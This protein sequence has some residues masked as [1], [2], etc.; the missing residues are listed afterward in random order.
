MITRKQAMRR[1]T[2]T[3]TLLLV[4][5]AVTVP[6][7]AGSLN[8][9]QFV[10]DLNQLILDG[11]QLVATMENITLNSFTMATQLAALETSVTQYL[12]SVNTVYQEVADATNTFSLTD[13]MLIPL[14]TLSTISSSL[15]QALIGLSDE[16]VLLAA[17]T[18]LSTLN[19]SLG[20]MLRLSDDI[21]VMADRILEMADKILVMADN[22]GIMADRILATQVIQ[23]T[24]IQLVV[25]AS[26]ET[27]KNL[28]M[29]FSMFFS[30]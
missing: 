27:Q 23:S 4:L 13:E 21:G 22:I 5:I 6:A 28:L 11:N 9:S 19:V 3:A 15:S 24:N 20:S 17:M 1:C 2:Q 16:M 8:T 25:A 12:N 14:Q 26:L 7:Q 29:L 10:A 18:S 30:N